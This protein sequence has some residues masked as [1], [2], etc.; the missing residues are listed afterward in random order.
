MRRRRIREIVAAAVSECDGEP[1]APGLVTISA[2]RTG[3]W[4]ERVAI[5]VLWCELS[6][7]SKREA[8]RLALGAHGWSRSWPEKLTAAEGFM[9]R[10]GVPGAL[11]VLYGLHAELGICPDVW[12][13]HQAAMAHL[14]ER[15]DLP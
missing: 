2:R 1:P 12:Q 7:S 13:Q 9:L 15:V 10:E 5:D 8:F 4:S 14:R 3:V 11:D 6:S